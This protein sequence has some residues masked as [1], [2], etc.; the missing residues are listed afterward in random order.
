MKKNSNKIVPTKTIPLDFEGFAKG[1]YIGG[2]NAEIVIQGFFHS[3]QDM[4]HNL[5]SQISS[6]CS[7]DSMKVNN[8]L[9]IIH[10]NKI[11]DIYVD[12]YPLKFNAII[13]EGLSAGDTVCKKDIFDITNLRFVG[14]NVQK[15]DKVIWCFRERWRFGLFFSLSS[16]RDLIDLDELMRTM[17]F[18]M[19]YLTFFDEYDMLTDETI[20]EKFNEEGWFPFIYLIGNGLTSLLNCYKKTN[21]IDKEKSLDIF[22]SRCTEKEIDKITTKWWTNPIYLEKKPIIMAGIHSYYLAT[23]DGYIST[24]KN[25]MSEI[26]GIIRIMFSREKGEND[27]SIRQLKEYVKEKASS[28]FK[29][30]NTFA[31]PSHFYEY[32]SEI[33]FASFDIAA[34]Q[35][36]ISRHSTSHGVASAQSYT[37]AKAFQ[38]ILVLDQLFHYLS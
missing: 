35:I 27:S 18:C 24:I 11:A 7:L 28:K 13:K 23:S 22:L 17:S 6:A 34:T 31:F 16:F 19:N 12:N 20:I 30:V 21:E 2:E 14:I 38:S 4:F 37:K 15:S 33:I 25:L 10:K 8:F 29:S 3:G 5:M 1:D 9:I 36:D 26:E 32:L